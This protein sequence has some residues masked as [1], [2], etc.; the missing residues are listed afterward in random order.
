MIILTAALISLYVRYQFRIYRK[1]QLKLIQ[2]KL[3]AIEFERK[4]IA[5]DLHDSV[6]T[7]FSVIK[8]MVSQLLKKHN[9]PK[10]EEI[11]TQFQSTIQDIKTIIYGLSPPGL[12]RYGLMAALTNYIEK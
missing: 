11:E 7:D 9:E 8:M 2:T 12:E 3:K 4:R 1:H 5:K 6:G 10:S